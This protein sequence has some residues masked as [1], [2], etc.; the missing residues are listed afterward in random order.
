HGL[1]R[2]VPLDGHR[3]AFDRDTIVELRETGG[4][5]PHLVPRG[6]PIPGEAHLRRERD[7]RIPIREAADRPDV[8]APVAMAH[9]DRP[10][11]S[12][13]LLALVPPTNLGLP[14]RIRP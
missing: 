6:G 4:R 13:R 1:D 2:A 12:A 8:L 9:P 7:G 11:G 14:N 5:A 3:P 10:L